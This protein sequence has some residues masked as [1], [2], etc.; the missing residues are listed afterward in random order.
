[1]IAA[2]PQGYVKR[3]MGLCLKAR[4]LKL[5]S[6]CVEDIDASVFFLFLANS[7]FEDDVYTHGFQLTV[8]I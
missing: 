3:S 7:R 1:M 6:R 2:S 4:W 8:L 5:N